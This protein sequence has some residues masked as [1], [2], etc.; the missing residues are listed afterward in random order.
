MILALNGNVCV[1]QDVNAVADKAWALTEPVCAELGLQLVDVDFRKRGNKW[2]LTILADKVGGVTV[3]DL[4]ELSAR[5]DPLLDI[6]D[7]VPHEYVLEVSSPGV[8]RPLKGTDDFERF[9]GQ[10]AKVF[11]SEMVGNRKKFAGRIQGVIQRDDR[12]VV[13]F[14]LSSE[15]QLE[16]PFDLIRQANLY[17]TTKEL[18]AGVD[19]K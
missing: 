10:K 11:L 13:V 7:F 8:L 15:E 18:L 4:S 6:E 12:V 17:Y 19:R 16:V 5:L 3:A 1:G 2:F 14:E 9:S